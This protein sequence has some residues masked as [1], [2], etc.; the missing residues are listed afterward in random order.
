MGKT[1]TTC[2]KFS[3]IMNTLFYEFYSLWCYIN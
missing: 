1:Y 2:K 3:K